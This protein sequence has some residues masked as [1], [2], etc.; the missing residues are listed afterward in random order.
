MRELKIGLALFLVTMLFGYMAQAQ[1]NQI[2]PPIER[3]IYANGKA[4]KFDT[5]IDGDITMENQ[6]EVAKLWSH[7]SKKPTVLRIYINTN[8]GRVD[9]AMQYLEA[10]TALKKK[11]FTINCVVDKAIS[12]G[13]LILS[14]CTNRFGWRDS[15]LLHH[16]PWFWYN[17][18]LNL[19]IIE[20]FTEMLQQLGQQ[21]DALVRL[22]FKPNDSIFR[23]IRDNDIAFNP[24]LANHWSPGFFHTIWDT[25][26]K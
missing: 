9:V 22:T 5:R 18:P 1:G 11:G 25:K 2:D 4:I 23:Y 26:G 10:I 15:I 21:L 13:F 14:Q 12:A 16:N 20:S 24:V 3:V 19:P 7:I 6:I 17:G 8:G